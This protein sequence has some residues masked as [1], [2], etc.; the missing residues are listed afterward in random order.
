MTDGTSNSPSN[1]DLTIVQ[2]LR[3][4]L[5]VI[6]EHQNEWRR[7]RTAELEYRTKAFELNKLES[8]IHETNMRIIKTQIDSIQAKIDAIQR[9]LPEN[10][11][12]TVT[13]G[14]KTLN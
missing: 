10:P 1:D 13:R 7:A 5:S 11:A 3:A 2:W 4:L 14:E 9:S 12:N 8:D 6:H